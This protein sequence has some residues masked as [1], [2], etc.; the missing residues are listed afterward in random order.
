MRLHNAGQR[1]HAHSAALSKGPVQGAVCFHQQVGGRVQSM[2]HCSRCDGIMSVD[3]QL[4]SLASSFSGQSPTADTTAVPLWPVV[5]KG[6]PLFCFMQQCGV[7]HV[8]HGGGFSG[9]R[10]GRMCSSRRRQ[11]TTAPAA[12][13]DRADSNCVQHSACSTTLATRQRC[14]SQHRRY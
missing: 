6:H 11:I 12:A 4:Q 5:H 14:N 9:G 3:L 10:E 1:P 7:F 8:G 2:L 13:T